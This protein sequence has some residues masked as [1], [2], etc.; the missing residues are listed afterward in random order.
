MIVG[1]SAAYDPIIPGVPSLIKQVSNFI[2]FSPSPTFL[3][4]LSILDINHDTLVPNY[5]SDRN[6]LVH[7]AFILSPQLGGPALE[8]IALDYF[9][10]DEEEPEMV[11]QE[12]EEED[13]MMAQEEE[14]PDMEMEEK[15]DSD[16][17][18][19]DG[20]PPVFMTPKKK[21]VVKVK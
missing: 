19:L 9:E 13:E 2:S 7:L 8:K 1:P 6:L 15:E 21:R 12:I 14:E 3:R 16:L 4:H 5:F 11:A 18:M 17:E 10:E 20:P